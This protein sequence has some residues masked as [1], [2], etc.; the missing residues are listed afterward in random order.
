M[1]PSYP[2]R[3][4]AALRYRPGKA[5]RIHYEMILHGYLQ[6]IASLDGDFHDHRMSARLVAKRGRSLEEALRRHLAKFQVRILSISAEKHWTAVEDFLAEECLISPFRGAI[7]HRH[8]D[9]LDTKSGV[10]FEATDYVMFIAKDMNPD[11]CRYV[12][13]SD[14]TSVRYTGCAV[15]YERDFLWI[16]SIHRRPIPMSVPPSM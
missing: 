1:S 7:D 15:E 12:V 10:C 6:A 9:V 8:P 4:P 2:K 16:D 14:E 13:L 5:H 3:T 11:G